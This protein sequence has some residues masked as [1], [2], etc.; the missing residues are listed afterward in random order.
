MP[1]ISEQEAY[2]GLALKSTYS[3]LVIKITKFGYHTSLRMPS[4]NCMK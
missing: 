3:Y 2:N 4:N 1:A